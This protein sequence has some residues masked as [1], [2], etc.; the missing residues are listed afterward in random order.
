MLARV[1][2]GLGFRE[3]SKRAREITLEGELSKFR[4][5]AWTRNLFL[6]CARGALALRLQI[7]TGLRVSDWFRVEESGA[8]V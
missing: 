8:R 1:C 3:L 6:S 7:G 4:S 5:G 2:T